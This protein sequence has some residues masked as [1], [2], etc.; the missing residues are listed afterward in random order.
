MQTVRPTV[1][2]A[3]QTSSLVGGCCL[4]FLYFVAATPLAPVL[5]TLM[6]GLDRS[7]H[8][9]IQQTTQGLQVILRHGCRNSP[10]HHHG[11]VA[12]AL[13]VFAQRTTA[14]Q[15]DHVIQFGALD[16]AQQAPALEIGPASNL[17]DPDGNV[18]G[19]SVFHAAAVTLQVAASPRS[20]PVP[21]GLLFAVRSTVLLI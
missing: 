21:T 11:M 12:R 18:A 16:I 20:P 1:P 5:I 4:L 13:T 14:Q 3:R 17:P 8:V 19:Y 6:A 9:A 15:S 10:S 7:H 2:C